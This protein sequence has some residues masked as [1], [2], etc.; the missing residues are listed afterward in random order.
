MRRIRK[1]VNSWIHDERLF[2]GARDINA[3]AGDA[4]EMR[5]VAAAGCCDGGSL[6]RSVVAN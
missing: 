3:G 5:A 1:I 2:I 4:E 6:D